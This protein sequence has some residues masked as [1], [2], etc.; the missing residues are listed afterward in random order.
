MPTRPD[1]SS[2]A[3]Q[4]VRLTAAGVSREGIAQRSGIAVGSVGY[5]TANL[6]QQLQAR[7]RLHAV[8]LAVIYGY[9]TPEHVQVPSPVPDLAAA[10]LLVLREAINGA[11][12]FKAPTLGDTASRL[13]VSQA[14]VANSL[15]TIRRELNVHD[16][17]HLAAVALLADIV[18]CRSADPRFPDL[19]LSSL[20]TAYPAVPAPPA[21]DR[22]SNPFDH[23]GQTP[24]GEPAQPRQRIA[25]P[26]HSIGVVT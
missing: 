19:V 9:V 15:A 2:K 8:C 5:R 14:R 13:G 17:Y 20:S 23:S 12:T 10:D 24:A 3:L 16:R 18:D 1:L 4:L 22:A 25:V 6:C 7:N 26:R 11:L 21:S